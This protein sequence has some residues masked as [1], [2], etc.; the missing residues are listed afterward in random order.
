MKNKKEIAWKW[1]AKYIK[2]RDALK[3]TGDIFFVRCITCGDLNPIEEMHAGHGIPGRTNS[4]L[5]DED[6][7]NGQ[8]AL[9]NCSRGGEYQV[10]KHVLLIRY[11]HEKWNHWQAIKTRSVFYTDFDYEKIANTFRKKFNKLKLNYPH[12][13]QSLF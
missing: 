1:F 4:I 8:C 5:F 6:L 3:T 12:I 9:C 11:G 10:Y 13:L 2:L 7:V